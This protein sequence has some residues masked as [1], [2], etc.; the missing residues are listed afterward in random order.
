M[1]IIDAHTHLHKTPA[2]AA[3]LAAVLSRAAAKG[4][5]EAIV[6]GTSPNDWDEIEQICNQNTHKLHPGYGVHPWYV[7]DLKEG[8]M[9]EL[10]KKLR[11][12]KTAHV[13]EIGIDKHFPNL[14]DIETQKAVMIEQVEIAKKMQ[15]SVTIHCVKAQAEVM[16]V[17]K[18]C[19][20]HKT[21]I[22]IVLHSFNGNLEQLDQYLKFS[23]H[24]YFSLNCKFNRDNVMRKIPLNRLLIESDSPD[25]LSSEYSLEPFADSDGTKINDPSQIR[26]LLSRL[27]SARGLSETD[28]AE[29]LFENTVRAFSLALSFCFV[30]IMN[31]EI[32]NPHVS[33]S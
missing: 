31:V 21:G 14:A 22:P 10:E 13:G 3:S 23:D 11:E 24:I 4:V 30:C 15:R 7:K 33:R 2:T 6:C 19:Q 12:N 9:E 17:L 16:E 18:T 5:I 20:F 32:F 27:A 26:F 29:A 8:W 1:R 25:Q 28:L